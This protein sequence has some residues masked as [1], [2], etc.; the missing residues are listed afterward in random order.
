MMHIRDFL[1]LSV[2]EQA[3][4]QQFEKE[5]DRLT[6]SSP[7]VISETEISKIETSLTNIIEEI[8]DRGR[9]QANKSNA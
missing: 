6:A 1:D 7:P 5:L 4:I 8:I 9:K 2:E 3:A